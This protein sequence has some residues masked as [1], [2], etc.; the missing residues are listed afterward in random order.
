MGRETDGYH[1]LSISPGGISEGEIK[2]VRIINPWDRYFKNICLVVASNCKCHSRKIGAILVRDKTVVST[3][4][5]GP[6]RGYPQCE[7]PKCPRQKLGY[8]T[9]EGLHMCPA[10]HAEVNA[11][12]NAARLGIEVKGTTMYMTC[13]LPCKDCLK[14]IINAGIRELVCSHT[15]PYDGL[16][17]DIIDCSRDILSIRTYM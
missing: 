10:S 12:V 1:Q 14:Y 4:Y 2:L 11:I 15:K 17:Q 6:P 16:S 7:G 13:G 3:G 5:N 9:G 8:K